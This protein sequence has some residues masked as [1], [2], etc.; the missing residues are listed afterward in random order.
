MATLLWVVLPY[1]AFALFVLGHV[2]RWRHDRFGW[3]TFRAP[4]I[5]NRLLRLGSPLIHTGLAAVVVG[6]LLGLF[7]PKGWTA[8][9]GITDPVYRVISVSAG[10]L[11]GVAMLAGVLLLVARRIMLDSLRRSTTVLDVVMYLLLAAVIV[12][13]LWATVGTNVLGAGHDYRETVSV[14]WRGVVALQPDP[15]SMAGV[16]LLFQL[17]VLVSFALIAIWPFTRLV[18]A[19]AVPIGLLWQPSRA[20]GRGGIATGSS[21][22]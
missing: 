13:G 15:A 20:R 7:V 5:R 6:H 8:A 10:T 21:S 1:V 3:R 2:W 22:A 16:P 19:W 18:H 9:I 4:L 11:A 14:W 12:L 17:H